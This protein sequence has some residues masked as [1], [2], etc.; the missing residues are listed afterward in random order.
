[1]RGEKRREEERKERERERKEGRAKRG[2]VEGG[3][4]GLRNE[5][6]GLGKKN[7]TLGLVGRRQFRRVI[8]IN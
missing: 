2:K 3:E 4:L 5:N 1:M 8:I 7:V 6:R